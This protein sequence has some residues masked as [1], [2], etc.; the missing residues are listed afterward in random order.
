MGHVR[1]ILPMAVSLCHGDRMECSREGRGERRSRVY[2]TRESEPAPVVLGSPRLGDGI[3][4]SPA[5]AFCG[6]IFRDVV[7]DRQD[8]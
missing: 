6:S 5:S 4:K 3:G 2:C 8:S 1:R 7:V